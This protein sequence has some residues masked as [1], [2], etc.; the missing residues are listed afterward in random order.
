MKASKVGEA[1]QTL[2]PK[3]HES[4]RVPSMNASRYAAVLVGS[5]GGE[6]WSEIWGV[7]LVGGFWGFANFIGK[8]FQLNEIWK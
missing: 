7:S 4:C 8:E 1:R 3:G 2:V 6:F 5:F